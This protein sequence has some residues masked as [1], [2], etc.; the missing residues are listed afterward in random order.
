MYIMR[1][2]GLLFFG[3]NTVISLYSDIPSIEIDYKKKKKKN[4]PPHVKYFIENT[5]YREKRKNIL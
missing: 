1:F 5:N 3:F 2:Y 4:N